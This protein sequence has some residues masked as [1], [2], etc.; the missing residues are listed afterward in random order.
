MRLRSRN[1]VLASLLCLLVASTT[2][3]GMAGPL[4]ESFEQILRL[5]ETPVL[6]LQAI[7]FFLFGLLLS[8]TAVWGLWNYLQRDFDAV[9]LRVASY[10]RPETH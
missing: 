8:A 3:A 2:Q 10:P 7:S 9:S 5:K 1:S 6:R 4:P